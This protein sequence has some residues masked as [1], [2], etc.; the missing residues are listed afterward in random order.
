MKTTG[1]AAAQGSSLSP[2]LRAVMALVEADIRRVREILDESL[3]SDSAFVQELLDHTASFAGKRLRPAMLILAARASGELKEDHRVLGAVVELIHLATLLHD[4]VLDQAT[5][6]RQVATINAR[7]GNQTPI[8]LGDMVYATAFTL[9]NSL[10]DRTGPRYLAK[11]TIGL[12]T[13]EIEQNAN[14]GR[15]DLSR[16]EYF[17][18]IELKTASLIAACTALGGHYAGASPEV[19]AA[20]E[21]YGNGLGSAFQIIDDCLDL[22]GDE[23][24]VGKSLGTDLDEGKMTLP[25]IHLVEHLD[26]GGKERL[27]KI[28]KDPE[29]TNRREALAGSFDLEPHLDYAKRTATELVDKAL[30]GLQGL[31]DSAEKTALETIARFVVARDR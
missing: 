21:T 17:R 18:I 23:N 19:V 8:L 4:D 9:A 13:G 7:Y 28:L 11:T 26:D 3:T 2:D 5:T 12:C 31:P 6:R 22:V 25:L 16:K 24:Q 1:L 15:M 20:L 10:D 29:V 30:G 27:K 14:S